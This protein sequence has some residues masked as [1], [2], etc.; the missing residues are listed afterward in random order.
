MKDKVEISIVDEKEKFEK[1]KLVE[2][3]IIY[4]R[5]DIKYGGSFDVL[6]IVYNGTVQYISF[7]I[8]EKQYCFIGLYMTD[9]EQIVFDEMLKF[10]TK[11]FKKI[12]RFKVT[13]SLANHP[14]MEN[15]VCWVLTVPE[16]VDNYWAQFSSKTRNTRRRKLKN[17]LKDNDAEFVYYSREDLTKEI[18]ERFFE[19]KAVTKTDIYYNITEEGVNKML[20]DFYNITDV[21]A[22]KINGKLEAILLYSIT[23]DKCVYYENVTYNKEYSHYGIGLILYY[24]GMERLI[25]RGFNKFYLGGGEY[26]Y[27][28]ECKAIKYN[29][30]TG[31]IKVQRWHKNL[32]NFV[33]ECVNS[34]EY[35]NITILGIKLK[36]HKNKKRTF[37]IPFLKKIL[38]YNHFNGSNNQINCFYHNRSKKIISK[39]ED[40]SIKINGDNNVINFHYKIKRFPKGLN[41]KINGSNNIID[42]YKSSFES[43]TIKM[44][45]DNNTLLI[46]QQNVQ[47]ITDATIYVGYGGSIY[48]G[49]DC[50]LGNGGL[51]LAVAGDYKEKHKMVIGDHT[52]IARDAIIRTSDG[53]SLIDPNTNLPTDPP[54][55]V[56]IGNHVWIMS[57]C[58]ILKGSYLADG[59]AVA[60]N[61]LVNKQ[62]REQNVLIG[63]TPAKV[64]KENIRWDSP[65]GKYMEQ[66]E[67]DKV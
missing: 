59:C 47:P 37:K 44:Y 21:Y 60:A 10:L 19:L 45:R 14:E 20:S 67:K 64:M 42:I 29:T 35:K 13:Q 41:L 55:D 6:K 48:I 7:H 51:E 33:F 63:G 32:L 24:Y 62:F 53:Q 50:E 61:S 54:Q 46:K 43:T 58:I 25:E 39:Y 36:F 18:I 66:I 52:H 26:C 31:I 8:D 30:H 1:V 40:S 38:L 17:F 3:N 34:G 16:S 23:D 49:E 4:N 57:R 56:I 22:I 15:K 11:K 2:P 5:F 12:R 65:Y 27:K 9:I 28:K